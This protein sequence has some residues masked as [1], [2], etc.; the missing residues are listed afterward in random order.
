[1]STEETRYYL[2]GI[3]LHIPDGGDNL[4]AVATD[5]HRLGKVSVEAPEGARA[6]PGVI[7]PR[8]TVAE[9]LRLVGDSEGDV[10]LAFSAEKM[11]AVLGEATLTSRLIDGTFPDYNRVIPKDNDRIIRVETEALRS[12]V[13]RCAA[14]T[15]EK[16][17]PLKM[18]VA[19]D[20]FTV[21][22]QGDRGQAQ[23]ELN[24]EAF[25]YDGEAFEIGFNTKYVNDLLAQMGE[26]TEMRVKDSQSPVLLSE[27]DDDSALYLLMPMRV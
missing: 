5:G 20:A 25:Q 4:L 17:K 26:Y 16:S 15:S 18:S 14:V 12:A 1:M 9:L 11:Q 13:D 8:K 24:S 10:A 23:E 22:G 21:L 6:M 2:N 3:Y 7:V 27:P 19:P